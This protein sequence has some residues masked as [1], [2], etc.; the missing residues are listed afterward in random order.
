MDD[1]ELLARHI[2]SDGILY[3][4]HYFKFHVIFDMQ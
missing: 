2:E 3:Y 1:K 4:G